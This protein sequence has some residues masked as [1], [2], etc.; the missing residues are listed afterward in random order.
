MN[1]LLEAGE[2]S[3]PA[4]RKTSAGNPATPAV[5]ASNCDASLAGVLYRNLEFHAPAVFNLGKTY[6]Q[7]SIGH[8]GGGISNADCP[9]QRHDATKLAVAALR[10][11]MRQY[12]VSRHATSFFTP[13]L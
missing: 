12:L 2:P 6:R 11:K 9:T 1:A 13:D 4:D 10:T 7:H 8:F 5:P 3:T